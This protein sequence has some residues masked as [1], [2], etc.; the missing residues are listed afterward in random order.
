M[1]RC[2][3]TPPSTTRSVIV[4]HGL[5]GRTPRPQAFIAETPGM[6]IGNALHPTLYHT[7]QGA[8]HKTDTAC[9]EA[10]FRKLRLASINPKFLAAHEVCEMIRVDAALS[11]NPRVSPK[12]C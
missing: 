7:G 8:W 1:R 6:R 5:V 10:H 12:Q 4:A 3:T 2:A 9:D 11:A